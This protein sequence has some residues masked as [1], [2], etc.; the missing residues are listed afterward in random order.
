MRA[1]SETDSK[2]LPG[3][4]PSRRMTAKQEEVPKR[5][6]G[7]EVSGRSVCSATRVAHRRS[8]TRTRVSLPRL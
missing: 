4:S 8:V 3:E 2:R 5:P 6:G 1:Q 7:R